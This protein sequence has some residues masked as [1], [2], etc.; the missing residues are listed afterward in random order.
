MD[1]TKNRGTEEQRIQSLLTAFFVSRKSLKSSA[2][3]TSFHVDEDFL[4]AFAEGNLGERESMP[5]VNHLVNC[6]FCRH[7]TAELIRLD[8]EFSPG[9]EERSPVSAAEPHKISEVLS[10]LLAK[11]FGSA[12]GAV[13]AHNEK[14]ADEKAGKDD[15]NDKEED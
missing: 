14:E 2:A 15:E 10:G 8:L 13:F 12:D 5:I 1:Y 7:K 9:D 6:G 4:T 3:E 11:I